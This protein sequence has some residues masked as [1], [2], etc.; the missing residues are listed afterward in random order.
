MGFRKAVGSLMLAG[1]V[2]REPQLIPQKRDFGP[3]E[4]DLHMEK[5]GFCGVRSHRNPLVEGVSC[6][7]LKLL[8]EGTEA[9]PHGTAKGMPGLAVAQGGHREAVHTC[10]QLV[11]MTHTDISL[12]KILSSS[13]L[14]S[15]QSFRQLS[16][17]LVWWLRTSSMLDA[18]DRTAQQ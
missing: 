14:V 16:R 10:M 12:E 17:K 4:P 11:N 3:Y 7:A 5:G 9:S 1:R 2:Y 13:G 15:M 8:T 18:C 6:Q